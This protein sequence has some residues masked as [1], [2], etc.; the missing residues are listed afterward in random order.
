L[1]AK[2]RPWTSLKSRLPLSP[3]GR[4]RSVFYDEHVAEYAATLKPSERGELEI[5]DLNRMYLKKMRSTLKN[6]AVALPGWTRE[7]TNP[8]SR[9]PTSSRSSSNSG[10]QIACLEEIAFRMGTFPNKSSRK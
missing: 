8:L 3:T 10:P 7:L 9:Q 4:D 6:S 5:T 1:I 2:E